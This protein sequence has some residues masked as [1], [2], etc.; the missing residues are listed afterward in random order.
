LNISLE[1]LVAK[2]PVSKN[3]TARVRFIMIEAEI[4]EGDLSQITSAIQNALKPTTIVQQ[5]IVSNPS[6]SAPPLILNGQPDEEVDDELGETEE[7]ESETH[8]LKPTRPARQRKPTTPEVLDLDFNSAIS[9]EDYAN[10]H[11]AKTESERNLV[12][13]A[14]FKECRET[15]N[16]TAAHVYTA[17]RKLQWSAGFADFSWPLRSLKKDKLMSTPARGE[18]AINH[19]GIDRVERLGKGE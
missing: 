6:S 14:W 19:L 16:I 9:L 8:L 7:A 12:I 4:P 2:Q 1:K 11:P 10:A 5:R 18:Y 13:A 17:Y 3:G 15:P